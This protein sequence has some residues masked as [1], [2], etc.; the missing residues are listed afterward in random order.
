MQSCGSDMAYS[1]KTGSQALIQL[2]ISLDYIRETLGSP[3]A[4]HKLLEAFY[5]AANSLK[6]FPRNNPLHHE[7]SAELGVEVRWKRFGSYHLYF[8]VDDRT[9]TVYVFSMSHCSQDGAWRAVR[10]FFFRKRP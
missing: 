5:S 8:A 2:D 10:D 6:E 7:L 4:A 3:Q 9:A 1:V